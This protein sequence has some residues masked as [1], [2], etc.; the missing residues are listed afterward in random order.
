[1]AKMLS[2]YA[3]KVLGLTANEAAACNFTDIDSVK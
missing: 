3:E 2:V 1:M